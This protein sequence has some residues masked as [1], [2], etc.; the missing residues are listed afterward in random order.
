MNSSI[1][2]SFGYF[3]EAFLMVV[4]PDFLDAIIDWV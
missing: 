3:G 2:E 4:V 1:E